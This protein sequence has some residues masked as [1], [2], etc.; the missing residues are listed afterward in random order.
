MAMYMKPAPTAER[1]TALRLAPAA[2]GAVAL[3]VV[4]VVLLGFWPERM[5]EVAGQT[6]STLTQTGVPFAG[7]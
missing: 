6:G 5:L 4:A 1:Y 3:A 2:L 7:P